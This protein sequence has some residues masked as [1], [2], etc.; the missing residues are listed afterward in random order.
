MNKIYGNAVGGIAP[1]NPTKSDWNQNDPAAVDYIKNRTHWIEQ[2][3]EVFV[4]ETAMI[5]GTTIEPLIGDLFYS[6]EFIVTVDGVRYQCS[7]YCNVGGEWCLGDSRLGNE[8]DMS[9]P[10]DVPFNMVSYTDIPFGSFEEKI[11][12]QTLFPDENLHTVK[13]ERLIGD[14]TYHTL[15][16]HFIPETIARKEYVDTQINNIDLSNY[17]TKSEI[18]NLELITVD[19]I[20][21]ICGGTIR[22]AGDVM[23]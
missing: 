6:G 9:N 22:Y 2:T 20:D 3:T 19:D 11:M 1:L 18:D 4:S 7:P 5:R 16:E 10:I 14:T 23:F 13:I 8:T 17:Y 15:D 21:T 12:V